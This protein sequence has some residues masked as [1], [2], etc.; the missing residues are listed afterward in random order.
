[1]NIWIGTSGYSYT[2]WVGD[3][4]PEA[5]RPERMLRYYSRFFPLVELNFTFY[6]PPTRPLL[7]RI[8]DQTPAGFQFM[9]KLPQTISHQESPRDLPQFR[10][11]V[12]ELQRRGKLAGLLCQLPQATHN[13]PRPRRWLQTLAREL[14]GLR[15]AVEFRH[16]S[17]ARPG[18][19]EWLAELGVDMV[20][21]D[22]PDLP[23]L[24]P[25]SLVWSSPRL[26]VRLHSRN[27]A[28]WYQGDKERYD[29]TFTDEDLGEWIDALPRA[30]GAREAL[31]LFNNC[32]RSQA[33]TNARRMCNLAAQSPDL[34]VVQPFA[35]APPVQRSLFDVTSDKD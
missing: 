15:L 14:A 22:V 31:F 17:W 23:S 26:Y 11:A 9:L 19:P 12:D 7:A 10:S 25:R 24:F 5:M 1:M 20:S 30:E 29:H 3:F 6:R 4:Y 27:A 34:N 8:A 35:S 21:V 18:V 33:A 2:D 13:E 32:H 28:G 16:R